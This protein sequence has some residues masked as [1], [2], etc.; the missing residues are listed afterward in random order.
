[1]E[2]FELSKSFPVEE[3]YSLTNQIDVLQEVYVQILLNHT[4]KED[5]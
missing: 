4:E 2:I 1:M 3:K 5:M